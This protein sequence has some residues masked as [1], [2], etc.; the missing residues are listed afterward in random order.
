ML[1]IADIKIKLIT[2][3]S[4]DVLAD[5]FKKFKCSDDF[6][7]TIIRHD[8]SK[9]ISY[10]KSKYKTVYKNNNWEI[11]TK[12]DIHVYEY[13][14]EPWI[15]PSYKVTTFFKPNYSFGVSIF[16]DIIK[17]DYNKLKLISLT[18]LGTDQPLFSSLLNYKQ[19]FLFH[20]NGVSINGKT[21][22]F[23][24]KSGNG[25]TTISNMLLNDGGDIFSDDRII[26]RKID[27]AF[28][29]YSSCIHPGHITKYNHRGVIDGIFFIEPDK[30]NKVELIKEKDIKYNLA[31]KSTIKSFIDRSKLLGLLDLV[32]GFSEIPFY[33][34]K[35][36]LNGEINNIIKELK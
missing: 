27:N 19:G 23:T 2:N 13:I 17:E 3:S 4:I 25:K 9:S 21:Y 10:N 34:V 31:L 20:G 32:E 35:F 24:G 26:I 12:E 28:Y 5:D 36:N 11:N 6:P 15:K 22:L 1:N 29:A 14:S 8:L 33:K 16:Q 7:D 18:G 30:N